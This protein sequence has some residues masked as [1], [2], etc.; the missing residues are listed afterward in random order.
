MLIS[1]GEVVC[2]CIRGTTTIDDAAIDVNE[3]ASMLKM[4]IVR[5]R[6]DNADDF[7]EVTAQRGYSQCRLVVTRCPPFTTMVDCVINIKS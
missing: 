5:Q 4:M 1:Y 6:V 7:R 3:K 2:E